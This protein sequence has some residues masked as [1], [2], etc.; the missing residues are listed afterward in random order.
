MFLV[1]LSQGPPHHYW[2][3]LLDRWLPRRDLRT[4]GLK[5]LA[6][7]LFAA[8]TFAILFFYGMGLLNGDSLRKCWVEFK[9]KFPYVYLVS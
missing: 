3:T 2:Y 4:V 5:V 6:D 7:Q 9:E 1:G 8:P